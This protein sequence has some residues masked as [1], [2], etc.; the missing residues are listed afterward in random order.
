MRGEKN[1]VQSIWEGKKYPAHQD[2][3]W[4]SFG[5]LES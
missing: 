1:I 3:V 2:P 5:A 4:G